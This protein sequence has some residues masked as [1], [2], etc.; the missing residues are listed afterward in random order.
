VLE[1]IV[2]VLEHIVKVLLHIVKV[3]VSIIP[4]IREAATRDIQVYRGH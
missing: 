4:F 1:H 3:L 2:K